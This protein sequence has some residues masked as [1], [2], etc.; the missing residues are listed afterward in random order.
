MQQ[1]IDV[2]ALVIGAGEA[3]ALV[4]SLAVDAGA[5]VALAYR[6]PWGST[7]LNAG[8]VPS[9]FLSTEHA[10]RTWCGPQPGSVC[11]PARRMSIWRASSRRSAGT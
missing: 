7:C 2:D 3:G 1:T 4:A 9:K 5:S 10:S 6:E 8:C 11:G